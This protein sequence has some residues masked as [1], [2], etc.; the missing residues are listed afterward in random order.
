MY[1]NMVLN[2]NKNV[3]IFKCYRIIEKYNVKK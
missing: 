2:K 3:M 1:L